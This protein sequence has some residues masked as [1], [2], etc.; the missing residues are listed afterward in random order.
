MRLCRG[1]SGTQLDCWSPPYLG[2]PITWARLIGFII[3][4][5]H[6]SSRNGI[7]FHLKRPRKIDWLHEVCSIL[8]LE[9]RIGRGDRYRIHLDNFGEW[10][11]HHLYQENG[12]K[13]IPEG[14]LTANQAVIEGLFEGLMA[15]DGY[16]DMMFTTTSEQV[17]DTMLALGAL[18]GNLMSL[19]VQR[20]CYRLTRIRRL[21]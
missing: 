15:S 11:R 6:S 13:Q 18:S 1:G 10:C 20:T 3:G 16:Q 12:A 21:H 17:A 14:F 19:T 7:T 8:N 4:D 9:L 5:G 2:C